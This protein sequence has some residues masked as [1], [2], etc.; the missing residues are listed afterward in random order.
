MEEEYLLG[1]DHL[2]RHVFYNFLFLLN[3]F[4]KYYILKLSLNLSQVEY[5][6]QEIVLLVVIGFDETSRVDS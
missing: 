3:S 2:V 4:I 6:V 1:N 5:F